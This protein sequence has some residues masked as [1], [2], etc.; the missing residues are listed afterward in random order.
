[1]TSVTWYQR[2]FFAAVALLAL[3]ALRGHRDRASEHPDD[4]QY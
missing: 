1:M 2:I 3:R 4:A